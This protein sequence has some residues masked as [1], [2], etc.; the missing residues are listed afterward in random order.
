MRLYRLNDSGEPVRDIQDRLLALGYRP[1]SDPRGEFGDA[2][3]QAVRAF[4]RERGLTADG[5]VGPETWRYLYEAG[6]RLGDRL[7]Y[8]RRPMIRGEDVA[9][10]QNRLSQLGF[11]PGRVDGIL[12]P[13]S[14]RAI[15]EFQRNR[16]LTEDGVAGPEVITELR[17]LVRGAIGTGRETVRE[18][19][20]LRSLPASLVGARV[21]FDPACRSPEEAQT[22]WAAASAAALALQDRGGLPMLARAADTSLPERV[23]AGRANRQGAELVVSFRLCHGETEEAVYFYERGASRSEA[24]ALLA[25]RIAD[26]LGGQTLGMATAILRETRAP[27]VIVARQALTAEIG[28]QVVIGLDAF[29]TQRGTE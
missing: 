17:L 20:W 18:R 8:L 1:G 6:Y 2:T 14:E 26:A 13:D 3:D 4:Q 12:G 23:R 29:F 16:N 11:D 22:A 21:F 7:L 28:R 24:G 9:E 5:E 10:L 19:E 25:R 15:L 27:A